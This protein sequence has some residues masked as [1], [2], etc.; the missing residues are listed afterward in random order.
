LWFKAHHRLRVVV[1]SHFELAIL[2]CHNACA[3]NPQKQ[4]C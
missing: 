1:E 2:P 4:P 3:S